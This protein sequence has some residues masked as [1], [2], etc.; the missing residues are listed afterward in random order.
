M[1]IKAPLRQ[2]LANVVILEYPVIY[3]FLPSQSYDFEVIK[4]VKPVSH[5]PESKNP[6]HNDHP[7]PKGVAF[8]EEEVE[9]NNDSSNPQVYDFLKNVILSPL[10]EIPHLNTSEKTL[11]EQSDA[12]AREPLDNNSHYN[13]QTMEPGIFEDMD[14]DFDQG[15]MDAYSD[16]IGQVN[17]D[18]FLDLGGEF[19]KEEKLEERKDVLNSRGVSLMQEELEEGEI[20][21]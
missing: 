4:D 11:Y 3:V 20:V 5:R 9:E 12:L 2:Q 13:S 21:E 17:P 8:R 15:L 18:D 14:F 1:D 6:V 19:P 7:S 16:L 10:P